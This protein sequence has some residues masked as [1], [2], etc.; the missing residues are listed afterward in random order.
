MIDNASA[1]CHGELFMKLYLDENDVNALRLCETYNN[2][3]HRAVTH[4]DFLQYVYSDSVA[5]Y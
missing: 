3:T 2:V 4:T 5:M 1:K